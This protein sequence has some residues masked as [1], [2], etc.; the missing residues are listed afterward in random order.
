MKNMPKILLAVGLPLFF[1]TAVYF[2]TGIYFETN[3]DKL[4]TEILSGAMMG[5]PS[6]CV[7]YIN[8]LLMAPLTWLYNI[9]AGIPWYGGMLVLFQFLAFFVM[10]W[11]SYHKCDTK[12]QVLGVTVIWCFILLSSIYT[13]ALVQ[14]TSTSALLAIAGYCALVLQKNTKGRI[15]LF[16]V[17]E[18]LAFL[19]RS[20]AM[21]MVQP[22]GVGLYLV[23]CLLNSNFDLRKWCKE[24]GKI[25]GCIIV[26][27]LIGYVG[28]I[29]GYNEE[30][31]EYNRFN[32]AR[33]VMFDYYKVPS[34]EEA[35]DILNKYQVSEAEYNAFCN[36]VILDWEIPAECA[37]ELADYAKNM[38][39]NSFD[40]GKIY[41]LIKGSWSS[42][43]NMRINFVCKLSILCVLLWSVLSRN[44]RLGLT[45]VSMLMAH[46]IVLGYLLYQ[47]RTPE[48]VIIPLMFS[49]LIFL[50]ALLLN[51]LNTSK[52]PKR[53]LVC[54]I[55]VGVLWCMSCCISG[56]RQYQC[57]SPINYGQKVF[58]GGLVEVRDYCNQRPE[59]SFLLDPWSF[60]YYRS[61]VFETRIYNEANCVLGGSWYSNSP[62]LVAYVK[63]YIGKNDL[64]Y[65]VSDA[66][67]DAEI[68][69][70]DFLEKKTGKKASLV[71]YFTVS[72][73]GSYEVYEFE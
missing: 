51:E 5:Q 21:L 12:W 20:Q 4:I 55:I 62:T 48:R 46:T 44:W 49:I 19:L 13:T 22:I 11:S 7:V 25:G 15:L 30:W 3:D 60:C 9:C 50:F 33:T 72:H 63:E 52:L 38:Y 31:D 18:L 29:L 2:I 69:I 61:S 23:A 40:L 16:F 28:T 59:K 24:I 37:E 42:G 65:I 43:N 6:A 1:L 8:Y 71:D 32:K 57:A 64:C 68:S 10:I 58:I 73:G 70:L 67:G 27:L 56:I 36:Y 35:Q 53:R 54:L 14:Y 45:V 41:E 39:R 47:G 34:Y 66:N 17:L 26:I